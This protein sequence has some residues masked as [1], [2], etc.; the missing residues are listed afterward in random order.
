MWLLVVTLH[1]SPE[2][3]ESR[4]YGLLVNEFTCNFVGRVVADRFMTAM[5]GVVLTWTCTPEGK[6]A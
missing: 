3:R 6:P 4:A 1:F 2:A 5:P